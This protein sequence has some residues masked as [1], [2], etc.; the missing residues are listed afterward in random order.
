MKRSPQSTILQSWGPG[1][2]IRGKGEQCA[3]LQWGKTQWG[4]S[5]SSSSVVGTRLVALTT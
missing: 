2:P 3:E 4:L 5:L 1:I